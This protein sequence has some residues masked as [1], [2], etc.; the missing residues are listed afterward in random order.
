MIIADA[1]DVPIIVRATSFAGFEVSRRFPQRPSTTVS[2]RRPRGMGGVRISTTASRN[3][4]G[5]LQRGELRIPAI[6]P[7]RCASHRS[8]GNSARIVVLCRCACCTRAEPVSDPQQAQEA[9]RHHN[10]I[11][12]SQVGDDRAAPIG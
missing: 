10:R 5:P 4:V 12:I 7:A 11:V 9:A 6:L 1:S 3:S 2:F 8:A